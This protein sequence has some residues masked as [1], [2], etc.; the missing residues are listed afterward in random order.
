MK[1]LNHRRASGRTLLLFVSLSAAASAASDVSASDEAL[2]PKS[3]EHVLAV[4]ASSDICDSGCKYSSPD[5]VKELR[6]EHRARPDDFF[7]WSHIDN[8]RDTRFFTHY[9]ITRS[10]GSARVEMRTLEKERDA[11]LIADLERAT[12]LPHEPI[13]DVAKTTIVATPEGANTR[14]R[15]RATTR[16]S[17]F[18][19]MFQGK[20]KEGMQRSFKALLANFAR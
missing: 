16:V 14:V 6:I 7:K 5:V 17:G 1:P 20:V 19:E 8:T 13:F 11:A 12:H 9:K 10:E 15:V 3:V 4:L 18:V 2:V